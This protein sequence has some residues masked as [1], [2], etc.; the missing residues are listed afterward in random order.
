[1]VSTGQQELPLDWGPSGPPTELQQAG[2]QARKKIAGRGRSPI[3]KQV[4]AASQEPAR[5]EAAHR[6][7]YDT[8]L[9]IQ[10]AKLGD[11]TIL[12]PYQ[13]TPS[14][15]PPR[16]RTVAAGYSREER[17]L[18][19]R[20]RDGA[21]YGYADVS[22]REWNNFKRVKS[23]GRFINRVLNFKDYWREPWS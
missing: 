6:M 3:A 4:S 13:P 11:D 8:A 10:E 16:P 21:V 2:Q 12:L 18:R 9:A 23:P 17:V 1:V 15:N 20:F 7:T 19:I 22:P 5:A 14:I